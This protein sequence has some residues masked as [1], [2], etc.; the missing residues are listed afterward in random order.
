M[1]YY[2]T[3]EQVKLIQNSLADY[4]EK[5][6]WSNIIE[7]CTISKKID[8]ILEINKILMNSYKTRL[9]PDYPHPLCDY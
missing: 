5:L 9:E 2:L 1:N 7:D 6:Q 8:A 3:K 4:V